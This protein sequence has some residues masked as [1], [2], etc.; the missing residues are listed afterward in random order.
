MEMVLLVVAWMV[1]GGSPGPAT[2]AIAGT[3]MQRGRPA[4]LAVAGGVVTGSAFWGMAA[5]LGM[6]ALMLAHAWLFTS[7]RYVGAVFLLYLA[8]K[9][10][11]AALKPG[12][13]VP[14][15][16]IGATRLRQLWLKGTLIHLTN[17]KAILGWGAVF[18]VAV[19]PSAPPAQI[20]QTFSVLI[21]A[22]S[23]V[24]FGYGFLFSSDHMIRA[25]VR[26]RRWFEATFGLLFGAAGM[27][28]L[29]TRGQTS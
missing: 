22:S 5:A 27:A 15:A 11:R 10:L 2:L 23:I 24:F 9:A 12:A 6:S 14:V 16:A 1:G 8:Y 20:W 3:A 25:Y 17:P 7:L 26:A 13:T 18:A 4:G 19:P 28:L 29:F 21:T